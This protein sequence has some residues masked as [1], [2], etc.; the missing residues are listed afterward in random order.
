MR[1][2]SSK[3]VAM[4]EDQQRHG[5]LALELDCTAYKANRLMFA[6]APNGGEGGLFSCSLGPLPDDMIAALDEAARTHAPVRLLFDQQPLV[7]EM[8]TLER[9]DPQRVRIVGSV[10]EPTKATA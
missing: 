3:A 1:V 2:P 5:Q 6:P 8:V 7:L 9:K 4:A 10:R